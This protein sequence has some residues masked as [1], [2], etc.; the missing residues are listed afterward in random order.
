MHAHTFAEIAKNVAQFAGVHLVTL[1]LIV[2]KANGHLGDAADE[3][4]S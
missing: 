3:A 1:V 2:G 4:V